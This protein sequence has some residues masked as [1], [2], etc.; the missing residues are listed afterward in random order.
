MNEFTCSE[1]FWAL[2]TYTYVKKNA[3]LENS[4]KSDTFEMY[5]FHVFI[6]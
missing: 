5:F 1:E 3:S 2:R 6:V 4:L